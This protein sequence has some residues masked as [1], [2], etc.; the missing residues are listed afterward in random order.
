[1]K[2]IHY[3]YTHFHL[4]SNLKICVNF[5]WLYGL[6]FCDCS[7]PVRSVLY[8]CRFDNLKVDFLFFCWVFLGLYRIYWVEF[9]KMSLAQRSLPQYQPSGDKCPK[10]NK[11]TGPETPAPTSE[12]PLQ[13]KE[14]ALANSLSIDESFSSQHEPRTQ[15]PRC[16]A[17]SPA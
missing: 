3:S 1:M 10:S 6:F 14:R 5:I 4:C 13:D 9:L 15:D 16:S 7:V 2:W 8:R 12:S 17:G 11:K